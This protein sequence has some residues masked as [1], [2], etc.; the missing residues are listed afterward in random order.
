MP[1]Y[2]SF[3]DDKK[4]RKGLD[5]IVDDLET[6]GVSDNPDRQSTRLFSRRMEQ[7]K[8]KYIIFADSPSGK[9]VV[10]KPPFKVKRQ[11]SWTFIFEK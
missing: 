6:R 2:K 8:N 4:I 5:R 9:I 7:Y 10:M 3:R 11:N 1:K